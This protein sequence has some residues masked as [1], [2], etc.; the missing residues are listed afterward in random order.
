MTSAEAVSPRGE[1]A[2]ATAAATAGAGPDEAGASGDWSGPPPLIPEYGRS[3]LA[4]LS[5][6]LLAA[7]G[8][9][10]E[11]NPLGL[12]ATDR[13]CLLVIDGMGWELL[14]E[15]PAAAPFLAELARS[16]RPLTAGFPATTVTSLSSLGTGRPPGQHGMLGYQV[17]VPG[18]GRL[19]N[20][21]RWDDRVDPLA[22]QPETTIF[23]RAAAA[24]VAPFRI[25]QGS[26][27]E[28]GFS[29]AAM[30]GARY[31]PADTLGALASQ[32]AAALREE[33]RALAMV[34]HAGLDATGHTWGCT[35]EAWRFQLGHVDRLAEQLAGAL[36]PG[37]ALYIT[38]DHGMVD[39]GPAQRV[40]ADARPELRDGV[41]LLGGD[42]R[43][44]HV[45]AA[46][47]AAASVLAAWRETLGARA[48]VVS[49]DEAVDQG[50]F[51]PV[52][53]GRADRIGDVV[54]ACTG[55]W[56]VVASR[57]EPGEA[58]LIGMHGSLT[59]ADQ[60]VPLLPYR[61]G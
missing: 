11:R 36:P 30:R 6:S 35:S 21:L 3:T 24:G 4:D 27:R 46:P 51:G 59:A 41:A 56:A 55:A 15:H 7:L 10:G 54:A 52:G 17:A 38:A 37:T 8:V 57:A 31:R 39:V 18:T 42:A 23:E 49:R 58:A 44:R 12:A 48:W 13:A 5:T 53:P 28:S 43:A 20:G 61:A 16:G 22:W 60:L 40:D 29:T 26:Y 32:A 2:S 9:P 50:W 33:R 19:L 14:R 47:G 1:G 34:Y 25:A 45:Y